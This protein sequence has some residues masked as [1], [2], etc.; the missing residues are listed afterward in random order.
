MQKPSSS[1]QKEV[2]PNDIGKI[3]DHEDLTEIELA[4]ESDP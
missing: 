2:S 3:S 4:E 1:S